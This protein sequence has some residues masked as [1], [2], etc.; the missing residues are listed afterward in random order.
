M[1]TQTCPQN[2]L[3]PIVMTSKLESNFKGS[4]CSIHCYNYYF[5]KVFI[6]KKK[7]KLC[8]QKQFQI[9]FNPDYPIVNYLQPSEV[10]K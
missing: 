1:D 7:K 5:S 10:A 6:E 9:Q 3:D 8:Y 2:F 4:F